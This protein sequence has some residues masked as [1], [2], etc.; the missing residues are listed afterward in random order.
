MERHLAAILAADMVG[1]SRLMSADE[2]GTL[3]RQQSHLAEVIEPGIAEYRGRIVKTTGDGLLAEFPSVVDA[4][5][6]AVKVQLATAEREDGLPAER[7]IAYRIGINLG[8]IIGEHGDIFGDGVNVAARLEGLAEPGGICVSRSVFNQVKGKVAS[9]FEDLGEHQ[10]KNLPEPLHVYRVR[11]EPE[12][13][14]AVPGQARR[15]A[16]GKRLALAGLALVLVAAAGSALWFEPW[17]ERVAPATAERM[18]YPL[19]DKPSIAVLPFANMSDDPSQAYFADGMTEDLITDLSKVSGLFVIARNSTFAYKGKSHDVRR[20]AEELGIRYVL[21]GSVRRAGDQVRIN[22]QLIDATTGGHLWAER[23]DGSLTDIFGLQDTITRKIVAVLAVQLTLGEEAQVAV[24]ETPSSEAYDAFLQGWE[25]YQRQTPDSLKAAVERFEQ[26]IEL[27]PKYSR[28]H[29]ALAAVYWQ[30]FRRFWHEKFGYRNVHGARARAETLLAR[31]QQSPTALSHQ[32]ATAML[33]QQGR[34]AEAIAEGGK[35]VGIDPNDADS[36]IALAG[37]Y[38]LAGNSANA[39]RLVKTA[40]RLNPHYPPSYLYELGL[41]KFGS[42]DF[43]GAVEALKQATELNPE[44]RWSYRLLLA[45]YG[46]LGRKEDAE[47][48]LDV[49]SRNWRGYDP[50]TIPAVSYWYPF[51]TAEDQNRLVVGL[52]AAN[53]PE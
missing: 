1:Y 41:A 25:Q 31:A 15:P 3:A 27:D 9:G 38:S 40:M 46:H 20:V 52:R 12:A 47:R 17:R 24:V 36:Y 6:C 19:P 45:T 49:T 39:L 34:H 33:A 32:V 4:L 23:Y 50:L 51:K 35:A 42:D 8:D 16:T 37:A 44:D 26:A 53:V 30:V 22:A 13:A 43:D 48:I 28:A 5:R 11:M 14:G 29:A 7:R 2:A 10:V 21:E 18:A